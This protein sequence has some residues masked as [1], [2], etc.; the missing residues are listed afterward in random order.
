MVVVVSVSDNG[1][2]PQG[3]STSSAIYPSMKR[4][5]IFEPDDRVFIR[6][7]TIAASS[8]RVGDDIYVSGRKLR[9]TS[10]TVNGQVR[11]QAED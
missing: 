11:V 2:T 1:M 6:A 9:V 8:I 4:Y 10:V 5:L 7:G 3:L